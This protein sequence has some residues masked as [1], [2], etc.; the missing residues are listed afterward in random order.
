MRLTRFSD[1]GLRVLMYLA[2]AEQERLVTVS[3]ISGQFKLP[4]NHVV[5]VVGALAKQGWIEALR[6]RNGGVRLAIEPNRLRI[7][8]VLRMLEGN[9]E[10]LDCEGLEC[11]LAEEC[12]LREALRQGLNAFYSAMDVYTLDQLVGS[13][14]GE[15]IIQL[16]RRFGQGRL[17]DDSANAALS[18]ADV[19]VF[20]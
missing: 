10:A 6:G 18:K 4:H 2:R 14:T 11:F 20:A 19:E 5:K 8:A 1:I 9:R 17:G 7:G 13:G 12:H 16:H 3:E 15:R